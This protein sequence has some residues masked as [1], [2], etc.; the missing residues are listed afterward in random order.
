MILRVSVNNNNP[1]PH[2]TWKVGDDGTGWSMD[3]DLAEAIC[4]SSSLSAQDASAVEQYLGF[5]W[6]LKT[7]NTSNLNDFRI[8]TDDNG[9]HFA[10]VIDEVRLYE[11]AL[12]SQDINSIALNGTMKFQTSSVALPPVVEIVQITP[13]ANGSAI[14][15]GNLI[16][17]DFKFSD[18]TSLLW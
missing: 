10:G 4:F 17:K 14:I 16:S 7:L 11:Y 6:G 8:G 15:T 13:E 2:S 3:M 1:G 18:G 9:D 12:S 5:K